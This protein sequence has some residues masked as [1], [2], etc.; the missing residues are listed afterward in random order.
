[1]AGLGLPVVPGRREGG[2]PGIFSSSTRFRINAPKAR[3]RASLT[4]YGALSGMT[5]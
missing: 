5:L 1:M 3:L 4:R 2:E